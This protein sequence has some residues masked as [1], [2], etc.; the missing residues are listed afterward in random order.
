M[1]GGPEEVTNMEEC[2]QRV[3]S[4]HVSSVLSIMGPL[5]KGPATLDLSI[6]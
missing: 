5:I 1:S 2:E 6:V 3:V 4:L